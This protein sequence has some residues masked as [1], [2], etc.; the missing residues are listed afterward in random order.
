MCRRSDWVSWCVRLRGNFLWLYYVWKVQVKNQDSFFFL[1]LSNAFA[2]GTSPSYTWEI[3]SSSSDLVPI[4]H[5]KIKSHIQ[6]GG[7][8]V[9]LC[10]LSLI[11][12]GTK[13]NILSAETF[14]SYGGEVWLY[15]LWTVWFS[16]DPSDL[17]LRSRLSTAVRP[18]GLSKNSRERMCSLREYCR[19]GF[20]NVLWR[21]L[22]REEKSNHETTGGG[23]NSKAT[24]VL[25]FAILFSPDFIRKCLIRNSPMDFNAF[26]PAYC[27]EFG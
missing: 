1:S 15:S 18:P 5:L 6:K 16:A 2:P 8:E 13:Q 23:L 27:I 14:Q 22:A 7:T 9:L 25:L 11:A 4:I 24:Y 10:Y 12:T 21:D 20:V 17:L 3:F 19:G 26:L